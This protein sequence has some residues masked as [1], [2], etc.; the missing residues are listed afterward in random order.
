MRVFIQSNLKIYA[1]TYY[2][3]NFTVDSRLFLPTLVTSVYIYDTLIAITD[4]LTDR[5]QFSIGSESGGELGVGV[6][7]LYVVSSESGF[8]LCM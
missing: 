2:F 8:V 6:C 3:A 7:T 5:I 4:I 1:R